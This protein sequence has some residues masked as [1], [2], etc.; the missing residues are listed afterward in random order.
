[1]ICAIQMTK[2]AMAGTRNS[3]KAA[4]VSLDTQ[5]F[6]PPGDTGLAAD[7]FVDMDFDF[8]DLESIKIK[9][10]SHLGKRQDLARTRLLAGVKFTGYRPRASVH[11]SPF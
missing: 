7:V 3:S 2:S 11:L 9:N 1:M 8:C 6:L 10:G 5:G 4:A